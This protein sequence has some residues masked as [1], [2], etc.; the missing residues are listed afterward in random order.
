[1]LAASERGASHVEEKTLLPFTRF[2]RA[3]FLALVEETHQR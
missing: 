3:G 2:V 1:M